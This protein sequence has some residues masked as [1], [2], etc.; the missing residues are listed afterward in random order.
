MKLSRERNKK[1]LKTWN[2]TNLI[3]LSTGLTELSTD[4]SKTS[5]F[6]KNDLAH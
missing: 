6:L 1:K 5:A 3:E 2:S 4:F